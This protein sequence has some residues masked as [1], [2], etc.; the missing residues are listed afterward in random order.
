MT[1][2]VEQTYREAV[3]DAIAESHAEGIPVFQ[4]IDGYLVAIYPDGRH[5]RLKK[6]RS[7]K[8]EDVASNGKLKTDHCRWAKRFG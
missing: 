2:D 7:A 1:F 6:L 5:V 3:K 4:G 8:Q